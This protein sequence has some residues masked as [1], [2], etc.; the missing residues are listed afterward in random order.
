MASPQ[1]VPHS[2]THEIRLPFSRVKTRGP[3]GGLSPTSVRKCF[4]LSECGLQ[5]A[6][7]V[8]DRYALKDEIASSPPRGGLLA[9]TNNHIGVRTLHLAR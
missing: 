9:M 2:G 7:D 1:F 3:T 8:A 5:S 6:S 4:I